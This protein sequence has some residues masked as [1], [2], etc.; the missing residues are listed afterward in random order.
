MSLNFKRLLSLVKKSVLPPV[1]LRRYHP[2]S[3]FGFIS[4]LVALLSMKNKVHLSLA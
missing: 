2:V 3:G 1:E 4:K